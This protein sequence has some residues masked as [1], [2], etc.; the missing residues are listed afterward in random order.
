VPMGPVTAADVLPDGS[1][2][3]IRN[4]VMAGFWPRPRGTSLVAALG[5]PGCP[6]PLADL[7]SQGE[8]FCFAA[9]G[10][11]YFTLAEGEGQPLYFQAFE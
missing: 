3:A 8:A 1:G 2:I 9:D 5:G 10:R 7:G 11:G 6:L 4:Y